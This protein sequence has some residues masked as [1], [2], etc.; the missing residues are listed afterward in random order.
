MLISSHDWCC[1]WVTAGQL[2]GAVLRSCCGPCGIEG[3]GLAYPQPLTLETAITWLFC[4]TT[5]GAGTIFKNSVR[6]VGTIIRVFVFSIHSSTKPTGSS[7]FQT[8]R[9]QDPSHQPSYLK[10]PKHPPS[11]PTNRTN[12][13]KHWAPDRRRHFSWAFLVCGSVQR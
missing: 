7:R 10:I 9:I 12:S 8:Q 4:S 11:A 6:W 3:F 13:G 2:Q 1:L 5:A